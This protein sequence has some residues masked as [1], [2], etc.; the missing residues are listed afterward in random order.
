[1]R[2]TPDGT[3]TEELVDAQGKHLKLSYAWSVGKEVPVDG[4]EH[5]TV[6]SKLQGRTLDRTMKIADKIIQT[7]HAVVSADGKTITV[8]VTGTSSE[9]GPTHDV[10]FFQVLDGSLTRLPADFNTQD[11]DLSP[12]GR[13]IVLERVQEHSDIVLVDRR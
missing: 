3:T 7:L 4:L 13:E 12:D 11:F 2:L 6:I 8:T 10:E 1:V 9:G 5:A